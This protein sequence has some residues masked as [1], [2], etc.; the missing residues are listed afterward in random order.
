LGR[1]GLAKQLTG[2]SI[3]GLALFGLLI[4]L[5]KRLSWLRRIGH[6][7]LRFLHIALGAGCSAVFVAH[8]G[9]RLGHNLDFVLASFFLATLVLGAVAA[10]LPRLMQT[11]SNW[12]RIKSTLERVHLYVVWPL[13]VL[14]LLHV[15]KVYFF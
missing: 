9:M 10:L 15:L 7:R 13:P 11:F 14:L 1:S 5:N 4:S 12:G 8:T 3:L 2:F 6:A